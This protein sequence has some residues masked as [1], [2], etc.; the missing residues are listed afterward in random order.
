MKLEDERKPR[1]HKLN[2]NS[3]KEIEGMSGYGD[4]EA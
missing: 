2:A 4:K 3:S 1:L